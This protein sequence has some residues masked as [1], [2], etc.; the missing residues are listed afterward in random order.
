ML[1]N[2]ITEVDYTRT[3]ASVVDRYIPVPCRSGHIMRLEV[4]GDTTCVEKCTRCGEL[5]TY[6]TRK[7][8]GR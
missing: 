7:A 1:R 8:N 2:V 3:K 5:K 4:W 6:R